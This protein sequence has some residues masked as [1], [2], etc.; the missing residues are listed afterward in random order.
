[1]AQMT[2]KNVMTEAKPPLD[3][4][5]RQEADTP[6]LLNAPMIHTGRLAVRRVDLQL[7]ATHA[8]A[9]RDLF[10]GLYQSRAKLKSGKDV[11]KPQHAI[12]WLLENLPNPAEE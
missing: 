3:P 12:L 5:Q 8:K 6:A 4:P 9:W 10:D 7:S 1:M 11:E 2:R